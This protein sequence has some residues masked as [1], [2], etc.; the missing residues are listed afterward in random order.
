[1]KKLIGLFVLLITI[2][3]SNEDQME[4][5][6]TPVSNL[7]SSVLDGKMLSFK[8]EESFIKEYS[9][10]S[11]MKSSKEVQNWIS[12]KGLESLLNNAADNSVEMEEDILSDSRIIYSDGLKAILNADSKL[13]IGNKVLWLNERAF[14]ILEN[15]DVDKSTQELISLKDNLEVYGKLLNYSDSKS[16]TSLTGRD[17]IP[18]ENRSKTYV[19]GLPNNN[20]YVLD[21]FNETIVINGQISTSK[22][23]V[24]YTLQ[25][26][27]CSFWRCT[28]KQDTTT[29]WHI[30]LYSLTSTVGGEYGPWFF[31][32]LDT[33]T[34]MY[35]QKTFLL[36]TWGFRAPALPQY[37]NFN[38]SGNIQWKYASSSTTYPQEI[39][40]Y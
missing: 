10:V 12:K 26:K 13:K 40:W 15:K 28:W 31:S 25:Y 39:S 20:R 11:E 4:S 3:C 19:V 5:N 17:V 7:S 38:V 27:S 34:L 23:Y 6:S 8:N 24:R 35:G 30:Y 14:Y 1:M 36:A 29:P 37:V 16:R 2:S 18:N 21:L 22:M 32:S 33:N 9:E